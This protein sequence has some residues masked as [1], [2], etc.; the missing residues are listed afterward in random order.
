METISGSILT[1]VINAGWQ[2]AL[3]A[4]IAALAC[5]LLRNGPAAHR[6]SI[7]VA[8]LVVSVLAPLASLR[9]RAQ[10]GRE[11]LHWTY[12]PAPAAGTARTVPAA[13][14]P[15][16]PDRSI[17]M[18][19]ATAV[20]VI[21]AY[22]LFVLAALG[23]LA[24]ACVRTSRIRGSGN[25]T[26]RPAAVEAAWQ[27]CMA[28][29][30]LQN[31]ELLES[32]EVAGPVMTGIVRRSIIL[33]RALLA[34]SSEDVLLTAIGHE[35]AH[36]ARRDFGWNALCEAL[37]LPLAFHPACWWL[38]R[39]IGRTREM[40][41]DELVTRKLIDAGSYARSIVAIAAAAQAPA[42]ANYALGIFD[43][44]ILETRLRRLV[45]RPAA[46]IK[47]AGLWLAA[48][49]AALACC[50]AMAVGMALTARA[51]SASDPSMKAGRDAYNRGDYAAA[52]RNFDAAAARDSGNL[53]ARNW[54]ANSLLR[55]WAPDPR[56]DA[57]GAPALARARSLYLEVL[58]RDNAN[59]MATE[60]M[61]RATLSGYQFAEARNWAVR[62]T[63]VDPKNKNACYILG[64]LD[65]RAAY[66]EWLA[67]R[68]AAGM[69]VTD[70][71]IRDAAARTSL[72]ARVLPGIDEGVEM[73]R[74]AVDLDPEYADAMAYLNLMYR[75]KADL[76]DTPAQALEMIRTADT[77]VEKALAA[78]KAELREGKPAN[79]P[80][81]RISDSMMIGPPPP[82]PPP[83]NAGVLPVS[84]APRV[85]AGERAEGTYWQIAGQGRKALELV[86]ALKAW[87]F[88][89]TVITD[90]AEGQLF[91][92]VMVGPYRGEE[93]VEKARGDLTTAGF[94]P[95]R[96]W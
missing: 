17:S 71:W 56:K 65:W 78:K 39:E 73:L 1:F 33:P 34:E 76:E 26:A 43:S 64:F 19:G 47:R 13:A 50:G 11:R 67:A 74:K 36:I 49:L 83:P 40:A 45:E 88:R 38:R 16:A 31:V 23:R 69:E 30:R 12:S 80:A 6:H 44:D 4:G 52:I 86:E 48:G 72:R 22:G 81:P 60:G 61:M 82:P 87:G 96:R 29:F 58:T 92:R 75:M 3:A 25:A 91:S 66:P 93:A 94:A 8:A 55:I 41:C 51:Q 37:C 84:D 42:P 7:C 59:A 95:L 10:D 24:R 9:P 89:V 77:W 27:R 63:Q 54:L 35:M 5:W 85:H 46:S 57:A 21:G 62:L 70:L 79:A 18:P 2:A 14:L 68:S 20:W 90:S 53:E 28:T 32:D 15:A